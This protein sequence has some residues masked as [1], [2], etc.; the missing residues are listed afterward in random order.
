MFFEL[1]IFFHQFYYII[2]TVT[3]EIGTSTPQAVKKINFF[4]LYF[5]FMK[6]LSFVSTR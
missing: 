1:V 3:L 6:G 2:K 5:I 4:I